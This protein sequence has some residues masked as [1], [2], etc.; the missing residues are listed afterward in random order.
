MQNLQSE[1]KKGKKI[2]FYFEYLFFRET[3]WSHRKSPIKKR[4]IK[5]KNYISQLFCILTFFSLMSD[6]I[7]SMHLIFTQSLFTIFSKSEIKI[8]LI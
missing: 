1:I 4:G 6:Q 7:S 8:N 3:D 2:N 5:G